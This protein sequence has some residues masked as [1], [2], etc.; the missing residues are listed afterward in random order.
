MP[1]D[2]T[3]NNVTYVKPNSDWEGDEVSL[4][5]KIKWNSELL[6]NTHGSRM[7][8]LRWTMKE[9]AK[10]CKWSMDSVTGRE[11]IRDE[12]WVLDMID[13]FIPDNGKN[14]MDDTQIRRANHLF[15]KYGGRRNGM[16]FTK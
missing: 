4:P 1:P 16:N 11:F 7:K 9:W 13:A 3:W 8:V 2:N 5:K 15:K 10:S 6:P 14:S 12:E